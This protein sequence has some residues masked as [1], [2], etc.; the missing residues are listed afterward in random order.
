MAA[1]IRATFYIIFPILYQLLNTLSYWFTFKFF[2]QV[3]ANTMRFLTLINTISTFFYLAL[4]FVIS[5]IK[6]STVS[7]GLFPPI[8]K[9]GYG[10]MWSSV[11]RGTIWFFFVMFILHFFLLK[12][13]TTLGFRKTI[14]LSFA[15]N[16]ISYLIA[17]LVLVG[18][19]S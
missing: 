14:W 4:F 10:I 11:F 6:S 1:L 3:R 19:G 18:L 7:Q 5:L 17:L 16:G 8:F 9:S 2:T 13:R 12:P 15:C